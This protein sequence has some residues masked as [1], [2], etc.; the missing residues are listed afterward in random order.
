MRL[1]MGVYAGSVKATEAS[2][3]LFL[4]FSFSLLITVSSIRCSSPISPKV[5]REWTYSLASRP[6]WME[7]SLEH[8]R[9]F[10]GSPEGLLSK[11]AARLGCSDSPKLGE[12]S[13]LP[14]RQFAVGLVLMLLNEHLLFGELLCSSFILY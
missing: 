1:V 5:E 4:L 7:H 2:G 9:T 14:N 6:S 11:L 12:D 13:I 10:L 3:K 8:S